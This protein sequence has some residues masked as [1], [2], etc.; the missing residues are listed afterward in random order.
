MCEQECNKIKELQEIIISKDTEIEALKKELKHLKKPPKDSLNSSI[1]PSQDPYRKAY[2]NR[3]KSN[4]KSGGQKGHKGTTR[5]LSNDPDHEIP[6]R[7]IKCPKCGGIHFV[8]TNRIK[9]K[10]Q[11]IDLPKIKPEITEY[12]QDIWQCCQCG[13]NITGNFPEDVKASVQIGDRLQVI[14][15]YMHVK[16]HQS[17]KKIAQFFSD[18]FNFSISEGSIANILKGFKSKLSFEYDNILKNLMESTIIGSDETRLRAR[19]KNGYTWVF[20][21]NLY[22]YFISKFS[23]GFQVIENL[24]GTKFDGYWV[25]DRYGAQLKISAKHQFCLPH[26]IRE[27]KRI[28]EI[29]NS[30]WA[31]DFK[32]ILQEAMNFRKSRAEKF[33]PSEINDYREIQKIKQKLE[34]LFLRSPPKKEEKRLHKGLVGRQKELLMFLENPLVPYDNNDSER[35]LRNPV[36]HRKIIG[37]FRTDEGVEIYNMLASILETARRQDKNILDEL[38]S[39][40]SENQPLLST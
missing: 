30:K 27:C 17:F 18:V 35:A 38:T 33:N 21:N 12:Q 28:K 14:V 40:I 37:G 20:L 32:I 26:I 9:E 39:I 29:E 6:L 19:G 24:F 2:S 4:K 13:R 7:P 1:P 31:E 10:R 11:V 25:S 5:M 22:C 36:L 34:K 23:R 3:E 15:G 8:P 16:S